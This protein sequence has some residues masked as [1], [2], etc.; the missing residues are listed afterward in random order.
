MNKEDL[1]KVVVAA[2]INVEIDPALACAVVSHESSWNPWAVRYEPAFYT[3]YI[4]A[5]KNL[6]PTEKSLR[7]SSFG[8]F[9]LMGQTAREFGF[10]G[11]YLTELCDPINA[12]WGCRKLKRCIQLHPGD[13]EAALLTYNGGN[14]ANYPKAVLGFYNDFAYL[15]SATRRP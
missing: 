6:T 2:A 4:D 8:L 12:I 14:D 15:N 3:R 13:Q 10:D 9:Q 7:A 1:V 11:E 5:M